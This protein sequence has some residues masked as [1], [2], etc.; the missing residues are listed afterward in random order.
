VA[1]PEASS[2]VAMA[3]M[4]TGTTTVMMRVVMTAVLIGSDAEWIRLIQPGLIN[5]EATSFAMPPACAPCRGHDDDQNRYHDR[6]G[7][8]LQQCRHPAHVGHSQL[9]KETRS[10]IN[11]LL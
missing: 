5:A 8:D 11:R 9:L 6:H 3:V 1:T 10:R 4:R 2:E 7:N